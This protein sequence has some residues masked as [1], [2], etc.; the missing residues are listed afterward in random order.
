MPASAGAP[1]LSDTCTI[2]GVQTGALF[3]LND[4]YIKRDQHE[5]SFII[6]AACQFNMP[7]VIQV[8]LACAS[9]CYTS[10]QCACNIMVCCYICMAAVH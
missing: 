1:V 3:H 7:A 10:H 2:A 9:A 6:V 4:E 5:V 8:C